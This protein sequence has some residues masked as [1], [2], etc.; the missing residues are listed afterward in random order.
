M[1]DGA[2]STV[3]MKSFERRHFIPERKSSGKLTEALHSL[4]WWRKVINN[5]CFLNFV[6]IDGHFDNDF[7]IIGTPIKK[8]FITACT[9]MERVS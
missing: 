3:H 1:R 8:N 9:R 7:E 5:G 2:L 6:I 4:N